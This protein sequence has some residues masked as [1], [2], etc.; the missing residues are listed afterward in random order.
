VA[1]GDF[2]SEPSAEAK[3]NNHD[4]RPRADLPTIGP[5]VM[6]ALAVLSIVVLVT[7]IAGAQPTAQPEDERL[8]LEGQKAYDAKRYDD[9]IAA[10]QKSYAISKLPALLFNLGQAHRLAGHCAEAVAAYQKFLVQSPDADD[11]PVATQ[12]VRELEPCPGASAPPATPRPPIT[13]E[14]AA[15]PAITTS[16]VVDHGSTKRMIGL[17]AVGAGVALVATGAYFGNRAVT[18]A[19]EVDTACAA[20]CEWADVESKDAEGRRDAK[21]QYVFLGVG[22]AAIVTGAVSY[23]LGKRDHAVIVEPRA[24]RVTL[25]FRTTF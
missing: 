17:V 15:K 9:A 19:D 16:H 20:G 5:I 22:A 23:V 24:D 6:R 18:L 21:L 10:W 2:A 11:A 4:L 13:T 8:Y 1:R 25:G 7:R 14:H 12:F 3:S